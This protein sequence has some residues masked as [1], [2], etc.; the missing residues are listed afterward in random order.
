MGTEKEDIGNLIKR[1][2]PKG[3][4]NHEY[5]FLINQ[6]EPDKSDDTDKETPADL[7]IDA[8]VTGTHTP[9]K[10]SESAKKDLTATLSYYKK[11]FES[12]E[13]SSITLF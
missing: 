9:I 2:F 12:K 3:F 7:L 11:L 8:V 4:M 10:T 1:L 6:K 5:W 13:I